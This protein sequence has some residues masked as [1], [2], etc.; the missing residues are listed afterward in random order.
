[1]IYTYDLWGGYNI[2]L[3]FEFASIVK[4]HEHKNQYLYTCKM[5]P[6]A[7]LLSMWELILHCVRKS[8]KAI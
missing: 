4:L 5:S 2:Y 7:P 1:M 6:A 8:D 3:Y